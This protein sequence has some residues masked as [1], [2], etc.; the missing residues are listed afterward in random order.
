M[1][2][3]LVHQIGRLGV[4]VSGGTPGWGSQ[5]KNDIESLFL[6]L[7]FSWALVGLSF[8]SRGSFSYLLPFRLL[9]IRLRPPHFYRNGIRPPQIRRNEGVSQSLSQSSPTLLYDHIFFGESL[10]EPKRTNDLIF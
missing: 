7:V 1:L 3:G 4:K 2:M 6:T 9:R 8:F 5:R 10:A